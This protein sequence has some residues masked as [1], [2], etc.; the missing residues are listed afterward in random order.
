MSPAR[1]V[2]SVLLGWGA[3]AGAQDESIP[4]ATPR[5]CAECHLGWMDD[6][7]DPDA[8]LLIEK[9]GEL[10][11]TNPDTCLGC[12]DGG[13]GDSRR[14]VWIEHGHRTGIEPPE[15]MRVPDILPLNDGALACRTCHT[16]H[17]A[18]GPVTMSSTIFLRMPNDRGE[19]CIACHGGS[20]GPDASRHHPLVQLDHP[21]PTD[22]MG[23]WA[24]FGPDGDEVTCLSCHTPHAGVGS[25]LLV[26]DDD[27]PALCE[28]CHQAQTSAAASI[29]DSRHPLLAAVTDANLRDAMARL[30]PAA[31]AD[32]RLSCL[33]CHDMHRAPTDQSLLAAPLTDSTLCLACHDDHATVRSTPHDLRRS[34]PHEQNQSGQVA[35]SSGPCS[36]CHQVHHQA[37]LPA[38]PTA[39]DP[40]GRCLSCHAPGRLA[41]GAVD[42]TLHHPA[43][44]DARANGE[45]VNCLSCHNPH[46]NANT[47]FLRAQPTAVCGR[48]HSAQA[49]TLAGAHDFSSD[50]T[51][52]NGFDQSGTQTGKCGFCHNVHRGTGSLLWAATKD[53]PESSTQ[54]C[55]LCHEQGG[56]ASDRIPQPLQHPLRPQAVQST[57][58]PSVHEQDVVTGCSSCHD[59]H[60]DS[61]RRT[62]LLRGRDGEP[63]AAACARCHDQAQ[64]IRL[65]PHQPASVAAKL[66]DN[67]PSHTSSACGPCHV[68]HSDEAGDRMWAGPIRSTAPLPDE[69]RC[70]GCHNPQG[71]AT[72]IHPVRH[73]PVRQ[74]VGSKGD[75]L[76]PLVYRPGDTPGVG[77]ISCTTC[78]V[79]HGRHVAG[80]AQP[81]AGVPAVDQ[82]HRA[83]KPLVRAYAPPNLCSTCHGFEGMLRFLNFHSYAGPTQ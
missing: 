42:A 23:R 57:P 70:L 62:M 5:T 67:G 1:V 7:S 41:A 18:R 58:H 52:K 59:P 2:M 39:A 65:T 27:S 21:P 3:I 43:G 73:V 48:C 63:P 14:R 9:P 10:I 20:D 35:T 64:T 68:V 36:A 56:L 79:P 30:R 82:V 40:S 49:D 81:G 25:A 15:S 4:H 31:R 37:R 47:H 16:A 74:D 6:F 61:A 69:Q 8:V 71:I 38:A 33:S 76:L 44:P 24:S 60:A 80:S 32:G 83:V 19:L 54:R 66:A 78:H 17:A 28:A 34:A 53:I 45:S 29:A 75:A 11:V 50:D 51:L 77:R 26:A 13:V 55:T 22:K 46:D 12:H 72:P